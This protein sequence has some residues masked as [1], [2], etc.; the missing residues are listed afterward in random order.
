MFVFRLIGM[1]VLALAGIAV[2]RVGSM[3]WADAYGEEAPAYQVPAPITGGGP[4][5][6]YVSPWGSNAGTM[7]GQGGSAPAVSLL[8]LVMA[9]VAWRVVAE[10]SGRA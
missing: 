4:N 3:N 8:G 2:S 1:I 6:S 9:L 10:L 7:I 5:Q